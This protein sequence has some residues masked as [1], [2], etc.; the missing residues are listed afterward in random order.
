MGLIR[1]REPEQQAKLEPLLALQVLRAQKSRV[2]A[3]RSGRVRLSGLMA[4]SLGEA[5]SAQW[6]AHWMRERLERAL[7]RRALCNASMVSR[8]ERRRRPVRDERWSFRRKCGC[9]GC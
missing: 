6:A 8:S 9:P 5:S 2:R 3:Y 4:L 1:G 7:V